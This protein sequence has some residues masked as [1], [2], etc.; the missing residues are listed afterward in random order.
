MKAPNLVTVKMVTQI[1]EVKIALIQIFKKKI[2]SRP[3]PVF[4]DIFFLQKV[5]NIF[6]AT[7]LAKNVLKALKIAH[8]VNFRKNNFYS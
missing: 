5:L 3:Q 6:P 7:N 8:H 2:L 4:K 1:L